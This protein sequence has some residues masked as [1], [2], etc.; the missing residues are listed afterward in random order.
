M[1]LRKANKKYSLVLL[2][3]LLVFV[4]S[5]LCFAQEIS[6]QEAIKLGLDN[7]NTVQS[8]QDNVDQLQ[9]NLSRI[10]AQEN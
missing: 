8:A 2:S 4:F 7:D 3:I 5:S 6:L 10:A 1:R 9:R